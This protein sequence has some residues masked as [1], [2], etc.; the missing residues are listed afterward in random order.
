MISIPIIIIIDSNL[1]YLG[2]LILIP[3]IFDIW[4]HSDF[5]YQIPIPI[6]LDI[7]FRFQ[8]FWISDLDSNYSWYLISIQTFWIS[9]FDS[10]YYFRTLLQFL[11]R[12]RVVFLP[13]FLAVFCF[14]Y[15]SIKMYRFFD[16]SFRYRY[17]FYNGIWHYDFR[18]FG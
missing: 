10:S 9:N 2:Y 13:N 6:N 15:R 8:L 4:S 17:R 7:W 12:F 18:Y 5:L 1:Y 14:P 16:S 11:F 3:I